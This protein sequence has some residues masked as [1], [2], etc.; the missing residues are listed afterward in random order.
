M[1]AFKQGKKGI[2]FNM[3][4]II[5]TSNGFNNNGKRSKKIEKLFEEISKGKRVLLIGNAAKTTNIN[6]R[7][8]VKD[9][10]EKIGARQVD[11]L[12]I[13]ESNLEK[14]L[15]YDVIYVLGGDPGELIELNNTSNFKEYIIEFLKKGIY[16]GESAGS[17]IMGEDCKWVYDIKKGT[18]SKYDKVFKTYKGLSLTTFRIYPHYDEA[19]E[20]LKEKIEKYE[21][22]NNIQITK[23]NNGEFIRLKINRNNI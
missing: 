14:I 15:E 4:N 8:D 12:D 20:E 7:K 10:F 2:E 23:L 22:E 3:K 19:D 13:D 5:L 21:K 9:N 16:I 11:L 6:S 18:K 1:C 17:I